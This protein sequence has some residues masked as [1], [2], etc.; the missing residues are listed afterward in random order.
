MPSVNKI[1]NIKKKLKSNLQ[2]KVRKKRATK[3]KKPIY[4]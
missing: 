4:Q 3:P 2:K 1:L